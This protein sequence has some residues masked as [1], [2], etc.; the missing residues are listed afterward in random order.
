M[1][2]GLKHLDGVLRAFGVRALSPKW[3]ALPAAPI[4]IKMKKF[5]VALTMFPDGH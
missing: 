5:S 2:K 4:E 3:P 1:S